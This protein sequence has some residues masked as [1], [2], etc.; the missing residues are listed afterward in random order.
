MCA[1][2]MY[3]CVCHYVNRFDV[4]C[5]DRDFVCLY[6][7]MMMVMWMWRRIGSM[8]FDEMTM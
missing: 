2:N 5:M 1:G 8:M 6:D 7:V 3:A 4:P